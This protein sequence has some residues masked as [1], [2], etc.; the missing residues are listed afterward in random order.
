MEYKALLSQLAGCSTDDQPDSPPPHR[1]GRQRRQEQQRQRLPRP[2]SASPFTTRHRPA[3]GAPK[4]VSGSTSTYLIR[5]SASQ[6]ALRPWSASASSCACASASVSAL[7]LASSDLAS[8]SDGVVGED[9]DNARMSSA[10][11]QQQRAYALMKPTPGACSASRPRPPRCCVP[12]AVTQASAQSQPIISAMSLPRGHAA[13]LPSQSESAWQRRADWLL[14]QGEEL[15]EQWSHQH[16]DHVEGGGNGGCGGSMAEAGAPSPTVAA[17]ESDALGQILMTQNDEIRALLAQRRAAVAPEEVSSVFEETQRVQAEYN[18][19]RQAVREREIR[20]EQLVREHASADPFNR[21]A[22]PEIDLKRLVAAHEGHGGT[23]GEGEGGGEGGDG[24]DGEYGAAWSHE[25]DDFLRSASKGDEDKGSGV[26][27][28][29][30][31]KSVGRGGKRSPADGRGERRLSDE[32]EKAIR[33]LPFAERY[34]WRAQR[35]SVRQLHADRQSVSQGG[36]AA[37]GDSSVSGLAVEGEAEG[38]A[39]SAEARRLMAA[40]QTAAPALAA[41]IARLLRQIANAEAEAEGEHCTSETL[42]FM[43]ARISDIHAY[44]SARSGDSHDALL[45][46]RTAYESGKKEL[47]R[48]RKTVYAAETELENT[49]KKVAKRSAE[50]AWQLADQAKG[51]HLVET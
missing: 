29:V 50:L 14:D 5:P 43:L 51:E 40:A 26:A 47:V 9:T 13:K 35:E 46:A 17:Q 8:C 45:E 12:S 18:M 28:G 41:R 22:P 48:L 44:S 49:R 31:G 21:V 20:L 42:A 25:F 24:D 37:A 15:L 1:Q 36:D 2:A 7:D 27:G 3:S 23:G 16:S 19:L 34:A 39:E 32:D 10:L 33:A 6:P 30:G 38:T 4:P 11:R